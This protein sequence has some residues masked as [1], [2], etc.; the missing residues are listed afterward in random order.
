M[1]IFK[2]I[3]Q[4]RDVAELRTL[5]QSTMP[6]FA[7]LKAAIQSRKQ[8]IRQNEKQNE[9]DEKRLADLGSEKR[10]RGEFQARL[11]ELTKDTLEN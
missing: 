5:Y 2:Q 4:A 3:R 1:N 6:L 9:R 7:S 10:L 8:A 11:G